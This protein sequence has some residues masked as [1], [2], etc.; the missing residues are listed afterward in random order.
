MQQKEKEL[1][2]IDVSVVPGT[3][4]KSLAQN[5]VCMEIPKKI[6]TPGGVWF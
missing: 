6:I 5:K 1:F 4:V 3:N 2:E